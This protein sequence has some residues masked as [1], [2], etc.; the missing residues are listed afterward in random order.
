[1]VS[2]MNND[3]DSERTPVA[4]EPRVSNDGDGDGDSREDVVGDLNVT[5]ETKVRV[6]TRDDMGDGQKSE[7]DGTRVSPGHGQDVDDARVLDL[8]SDNY[9]NGED[10]AGV[11]SGNYGVHG[12]REMELGVQDEKSRDAQNPGVDS[13]DDRTIGADPLGSPGASNSDATADDAMS[14]KAVHSLEGS[15]VDA[16]NGDF[17]L[18]RRSNLRALAGNDAGAGSLDDVV[19]AGSSK[20]LGSGFEMGDMVWGKVKSHPWWPGHIYNEAFATS[21]VRRSRRDGHVLVAFFGDSSYGWFDPTELIPY[22]P[23]YAEKSQQTN[24]RNFMNAV[25]ESVD[26]ASRRSALGLSCRCRNPYN[27]RAANVPGYMVVDVVDYEPGAIYSVIQIQN[28]R[29]SFRPVETLSFIKQLAAA[30]RIGE[31]KS[32]DF[33]KHKAITLAYRRSVFEE[34][35]ETY[36]Q[37]FGQQPVRHSQSPT[38]P[39]EPSRAP[40]SGPLVIAEALGGR[41]SSNKATKPKELSK[42]DRYLFKRRDEGGNLRTSQT[43][44]ARGSYLSS[45]AN[46]D[47][48][49]DSA[50]AS[51]VFQKRDPAVSVKD[52]FGVAPLRDPVAAS[53]RAVTTKD[54]PTTGLDVMISPG[55]SA[56][57]HSLGVTSGPQQSESG[58]VMSAVGSDMHG[59]V[60]DSRFGNVSSGD[61]GHL[62]LGGGPVKKKKKAKRSAAEL[63][64]E[65]PDT[66]DKKMKKLKKTE[67]ERTAVHLETPSSGSGGLSKPAGKPMQISAALT[68][69]KDAEATDSLSQPVDLVPSGAVEGREDELPELLADLLGL[70]LDPFHGVERNR[71]AIVRQFFLKFRSVVYLKSSSASPPAES[72]P[73]E[74]RSIRSPPRADHD[75]TLTESAKNVRPLKLS[76]FSGRHDDPTKGGRKRVPSERQEEIAAKRAKKITEVKSLAAEKKALLKNPEMQ[77]VDGKAKV[78]AVRQSPSRP[79]KI[80][81]EQHVKKADRPPRVEEPTYLVMKFQSG[82]SLPSLMELK[83]RFARFGPLDTSLSRVF[84]KTNTCRVAFLYKQDAHVAYRYAVGSKSV[85]SNVKFMLKPVAEPQLPSSVKA[86]D[87]IE[88]VSNRDSSTAEPRPPLSAAPLLPSQPVQQL[89]SCLKRPSGNDEPGGPNNGSGS[90]KATRVRFNMGEDKVGAS[91]NRPGVQVQ[92][93]MSDSRNANLSSESGPSS[94]SSP[95]SVAMDTVSNNQRFISSRPLQPP[96]IPTPPPQFLRPPTINRPDQHHVELPPR[97]NPNYNV[98]APPIQAQLPPPPPPPPLGID[99]SQQMISLLTRCHEVVTNVTSILGYVP[100]HSL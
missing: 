55:V 74:A 37:A 53:P 99:I 41:K 95:S 67:G 40:L 63:N 59:Q 3:F 17:R 61:G 85:F 56:K 65:K 19:A 92:L 81:T 23:H 38:V 77:Q 93:Q 62:G 69:R 51:Y 78:A 72:E 33:I 45:S 2:V 44:Q 79:M 27:F 35:D 13:S 50:A 58:V 71:P 66:P 76:K 82:S 28:A 11:S 36:A 87:H 5:E 26:E 18:E 98:T 70:A 1:M 46:D 42:K 20:I 9:V 21:S 83:A 31:S 4:D 39:V 91:S 88:P 60:P 12:D 54:I 52:E 34:F 7:M 29:E 49:S 90:V 89:K 94:S 86:D 16:V 6:S 15:V 10:T 8:D 32:L 80:R 22:E 57:R 84:Y 68:E 43:I 100:Y 96:L 48:T 14:Q 25:E 30:P 97:N 73:S 64:S 47:G 75:R 24:S